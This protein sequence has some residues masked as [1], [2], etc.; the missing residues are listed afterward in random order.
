MIEHDY[1]FIVGQLLISMVLE[2]ICFRLA[3]GTPEDDI[4]SC[5]KYL[6]EVL[7]ETHKLQDKLEDSIRQKMPQYFTSGPSLGSYSLAFQ[8]AASTQ[9][10]I[11]TSQIYS[12]FYQSLQRQ[13]IAAKFEMHRHIMSV[14]E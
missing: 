14:C 1:S 13:Q 7:Q 3:E 8:C 4:P 11:D 12:N 9:R 2:I 10:N 5:R 6:D